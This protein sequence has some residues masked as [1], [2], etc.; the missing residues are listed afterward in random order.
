[1]SAPLDRRRFLVSAAG[2]ASILALRCAS[3]QSAGEAPPD[4]DPLERVHSRGRLTV[5]PTPPSGPF[6]GP[7]TE[8]LGIGSERDGIIYAP[9]SYSPERP[10]PLVLMLHG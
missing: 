4:S 9:A 3:G 7:G 10:A 1:M 8:A 6:G 2:A 5:R